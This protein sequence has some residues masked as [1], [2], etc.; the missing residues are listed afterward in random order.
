MLVS[1][2]WGVMKIAPVEDFRAKVDF[3]LYRVDLESNC[4]KMMGFKYS[5][6]S[7]PPPLG[8]HPPGL[9]PHLFMLIMN[10]F[11]QS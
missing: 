4:R 5:D 6:P 7:T 8:V 10:R 2:G 9:A 1:V 3:L 11:L